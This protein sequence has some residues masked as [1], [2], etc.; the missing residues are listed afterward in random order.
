MLFWLSVG[1]LSLFENL[2]NQVLSHLLSSCVS[3]AG[4]FMLTCEIKGTD[5]SVLKWKVLQIFNSLSSRGSPCSLFASISNTN[6]RSMDSIVKNGHSQKELFL[7]YVKMLK[8][9][10]G[11][12]DV[13]SLKM[14][15]VLQRTQLNL[16][17]YCPLTNST[18][19]DQEHL[20]WS[21]ECSF[22]SKAESIRALIL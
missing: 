14:D 16:W 12:V 8:D 18:E 15:S 19:Q 4:V 21:K 17:V 2:R 11:F 1:F 10:L 6:F 22:C 7:C 13:A 9:A 5:S 20:F 3:H